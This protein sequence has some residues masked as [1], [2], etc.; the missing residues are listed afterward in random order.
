MFSLIITIVSIAL[1]A[2]L[3][4][5]SVVYAGKAFKDADTSAQIAQTIQEGA[6]IAATVQVYLVYESAFPTGSAEEIGNELVEKKISQQFQ[7]ANG[8]SDRA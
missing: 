7:L 8:S 3:A 4:I 5:A 2:I 1:V 6:Q